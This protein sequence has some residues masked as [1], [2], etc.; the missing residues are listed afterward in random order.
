MSSASPG[1]Y[2]PP[3]QGGGRWPTAQP[4]SAGASNLPGRPSATSRV[5]VAADSS[6]LIITGE[7]VALELRPASVLTRM[8]SGVIDLVIFAVVGGGII[9]LATRFVT[10]DSRLGVVVVSTMALVMVVLPTAVETLTRGLSAGK[11]AAGI[12][13]VRDDGG[14]VRFRQAFVRALTAVG[15]IWFSFGSI[16]LITSIINRRG[17]RLGDLLAGTYAVRVRGTEVAV[18]PLLMPPDL[19]EWAERAD[20]RR[21]PDN[22]ALHAR[23]FLSRTGQLNPAVR[24]D[25]GRLFAA[26]MEPYVSPPPPWGTNPERFVAAVLVARRDREYQAGLAS[27]AKDAEEVERMRRL[28]YG[29]SDAA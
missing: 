25:L 20:I 19:Q 7:A 3:S 1:P 5:G 2:A 14:P 23:I 28:P 12:R 17:K 29:I 11:V 4:G 24:I 10:N 27:R 26:T 18:A 6:D 16:A 21:L 13:V 15:E 22:L 8:M 9:L